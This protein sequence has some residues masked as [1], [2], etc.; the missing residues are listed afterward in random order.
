MELFHLLKKFQ[1]IEA[2]KAYTETSKSVILSTPRREAEPSSWGELVRLFG[3]DM[4][5]H[6]SSFLLR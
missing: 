6:S 4:I 5:G 1:H 3:T 2:S